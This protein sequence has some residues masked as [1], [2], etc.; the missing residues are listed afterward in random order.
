MVKCILTLDL[1]TRSGYCLWKLG[2]KPVLGNKNFTRY[3]DN[4]DARLYYFEKWL[5]RLVRINEVDFIV[6]EAPILV[7]N[8]PKTTKPATAFILMN[9]AGSP[10]RIGFKHGARVSHC[11]ADRWRSKVLGNGR[12]TSD[13]AKEKAMQFARD[14]GFDPKYHDEADAFCLM[15]YTA[16]LLDIKRAWHDSWEFNFD[17]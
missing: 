15:E 9:L 1:A 11:R 2:S 17:G 7:H 8:G 3:K 6:Y 4:M 12:L 13:E 10:H 16:R 14:C 5:D